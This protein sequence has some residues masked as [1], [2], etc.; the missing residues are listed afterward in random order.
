MLREMIPLEVSLA[1]ESK[2]GALAPQMSSLSLLRRVVVVGH[3]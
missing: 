3:S 2:I 1:A